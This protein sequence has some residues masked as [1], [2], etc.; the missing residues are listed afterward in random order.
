MVTCCDSFLFP[1]Q[2][3]SRIPGNPRGWF[4]R[5]HPGKP[6]HFLSMVFRALR[7]HAIFPGRLRNRIPTRWSMFDSVH[8]FLVR[9]DN[10]SNIARMKNPTAW[11]VR[12]QC[13]CPV[14][15]SAMMLKSHVIVVVVVVVVVVSWYLVPMFMLWIPCLL[16][17]TSHGD[18]NTVH[19][20]MS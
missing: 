7:D 20:Q 9:I 17:T 12:Y 6:L 1:C 19:A 2:A 18:T 10:A 14:L 11:L 8:V 16:R 4:V 5:F 15:T 13:H 3:S